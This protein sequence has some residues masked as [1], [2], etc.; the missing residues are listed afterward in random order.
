LDAVTGQQ[1]DLRQQSTYRF[2][3]SNAALITGRFALSFGAL[4]PLAAANG[5]AATSVSVYPNPAH[6]QFLVLVPAVSGATQVEA[7]L[8]N[9]LGQVVG[10]YSAALPAAGTNLTIDATGLKAGVYTIRLRAGATT[11][12]KRVVI[13]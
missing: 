3:A 1:V 2:S 6:Q 13:Q 5:F 8:V 12:A 10:H 7:D 4:R 11:V 9:V